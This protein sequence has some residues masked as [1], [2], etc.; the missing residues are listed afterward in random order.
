MRLQLYTWN[1]ILEDGEEV[2]AWQT[3][4]S[5]DVIYTRPKPMPGDLDTARRMAYELGELN[6]LQEIQR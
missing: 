4:R 3:N 2:F 1:E 6:R 5:R